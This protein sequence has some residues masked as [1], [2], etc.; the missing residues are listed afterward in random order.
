[1]PLPLSTQSA[2]ISNSNIADGDGIVDVERIFT[3]HPPRPDAIA[4]PTPPAPSHH[5]CSDTYGL[6]QCCTPIPLLNALHNV[7]RHPNSVSNC[8]MG[9]V[10][11]YNVLTGRRSHNR[12]L[13][14]QDFSDTLTEK[15]ST[16]CMG[17]KI[18]QCRTIMQMYLSSYICNFHSYNLSQDNTI[19]YQI[20]RRFY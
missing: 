5:V 15:K 2:R 20:N 3:I 11:M 17:R 16:P 13:S 8:E 7:H 10:Q 6:K 12:R 9:R 19:S 4:R 1:M 18:A 14:Q